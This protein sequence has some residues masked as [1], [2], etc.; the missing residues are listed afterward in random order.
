MRPVL[1][2][3][4]G[5]WIGSAGD[6]GG[7]DPA[8][9][10]AVRGW[11]ER[12]RYYAVDLP[13]EINKLYYEG[14][15][16]QT[17]WPLFHHFPMLL[18]FQP[19]AWNAYREANRRFCDEVARHYRP[20]DM[21]WIH[22]YH[23]M[24]LPQMLREAIPGAAIG[25]FLHIPFPSSEVFRILPRRDELLQGLLGADLLAFQTHSHLQHFRTSLQRIAGIASSMA[26]V[27]LG[28]RSLKLECLPIGIAAD[29]FLSALESPEAGEHRQSLAKR[30]EGRRIL[31]AIDR[32]DYTK[33]IPERMRAFRRLL[34]NAPALRGQIV[35]VQVAVPS[36]EGIG[37][38]IGL[39]R[40]VNELVGEIN[41]QFG[42]PE[43]TPIVYIRRSI[44]R[45][46]LAALYA[47]ADVAWVTP[48][49]DGMNL[50][51]KEYIGCKPSGNGALVL[52][53]F[54]GAAEELG[55]AFIVNP[56]D[57]ERTAET[58]ERV[59]LLDA[60]ERRERMAALHARVARNNVHAWSERFLQAL[61]NAAAARAA[62]PAPE[63]P[64]LPHEE[65]A[66]A[67]SRARTRVLFLDYDGTL[68]DYAPRPELAAPPAGL[69]DLIRRLVDSPRNTVVVI[70]G[71]RASNLN[72]WFESVP[73]LWLVAEHGGF[74]RRPG[75]AW[76]PLSPP[77]PEWK[78][79]VRPVLEHFVERT[80]GSFV[81]E[82][83]LS[84][85]WHYRLADPEYGQ[86]LA[87]ELGATLDG[88]L[89]ETDLRPVRGNKN[90]EIRPIWA[91]KGNAAQRILAAVGDVDFRFA[92]GDDRTDEDVFAILE[93]DD[94]TV[95]VGS[96]ATRAR[97]YVPDGRT[98]RALLERFASIDATGAAGA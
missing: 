49:R 81:E 89:A 63:A 10:A 76:A 7:S 38:Y 57:E 88:M 25:W 3:T 59:L 20:G 93:P 2:K 70:S 97:F 41:G 40:T 15:A 77:S 96:T 8:R 47:A 34:E 50:V 28:T 65:L 21:V 91:N 87:N 62:R 27:D 17:L 35:L 11:A 18:R 79:R 44:S 56:Y 51:A 4:G 84:L 54:A 5:L 46:Q 75:G 83:E 60:A 16:N 37:S 66:S 68:R 19:D 55:E 53:E 48:L 85:T 90:V 69:M 29:E 82:K 78:E 43:W 23:L 67:Y 14:F 73:G 64:A 6:S 32:L 26:D 86:W 13:P 42:T 74:L 31:V 61:A 12:D 39:Q 52:S 98:V 24:L 72:A 36:R 22:D 94:W 71:R 58:L 95:R 92:A 80:P 30:F 1:D 9:A 33:G 45:P